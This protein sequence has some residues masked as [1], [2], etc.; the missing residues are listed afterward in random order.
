[1]KYTFSTLLLLINLALFSQNLELV[2]GINTNRFFDFRE[3]E[4]HFNST[5]NSQ[6]GY[7]F[8]FAIQDVKIETL[9]WRFTLGYEKYGGE[10][11]VKDGGRG[12]G[13]TT[14][15]KIGKSVISIGIFPLNFKIIDR[16]D[17]NV[18]F[19]IAGLISENVNGT[20]SGWTIYN[21][22][23]SHDLNDE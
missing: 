18:G 13:Y 17:I 8:R 16:I 7:S 19:E 10:I 1:M 21:P 4:G 2:G 15:A 9:K 3:G 6:L 12:G 5:Y 23:Y 22:S 11:N 20:R 14:Q